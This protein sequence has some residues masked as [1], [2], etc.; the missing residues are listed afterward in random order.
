MHFE[1]KVMDVVMNK[2][3]QDI[4]GTAKDLFWKYGI[5]RVSI[6]EICKESNVSKM[7]FYKF[8]PNKIELA[9]TI[10]DDLVDSSLE[11]L[12]E[13]IHGDKPF[14]D[15]LKAMFLMKLEGMNNVSMEF[16]KDIHINQG[17]GL[18]EHMDKLQAKSI[19]LIV[20]FYKD[21]QKKGYIR[22]EVKI[23]FI[24]AYSTQIIKLMEDEH[25]LSQYEQPQ[26]LVIE[27]MNLLFYGIITGNE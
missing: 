4:F 26:D 14:S 11:R 3:Y 6:E 22:K 17:T 27:S 21:S 20:D 24:L 2:K 16:I 15:K 18:K 5:K 9:K 8:F 7:T 13:I 12:N 19:G 23:D 10:M 25:L 1:R